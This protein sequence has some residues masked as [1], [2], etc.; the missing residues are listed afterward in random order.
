[1]PAAS[2]A[3]ATRTPR[4]RVVIA[5]IAGAWIVTVVAE[6]TGTGSLLHHHALIEDGP[7]L[8]AALTLFL[9]AWQVMV[10]AMMLPASLPA[11]GVF[12]AAARI[13]NRP[14]LALAVFVAAYAVVWTAFGQLAFMGDVVL[15]HVVD[16]TPWLGARPWLIE[17]GVLTFAGAYQFAPNKRHGLL[18]CRHPRVRAS[19]APRV[20]L[21]AFRLGLEHGF[22]C[23]GSSGALMLVMFA[24]GFA[25]LWWMIAL[26]G[27]MVYETTGR[28]AER[29]A[30]AAGLALIGLAL[31]V[32]LSGMQLVFVADLMWR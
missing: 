2:A 3:S 25:N 12:T 19:I 30:S 14:G 29:A 26:T 17:V 21:G 13:Q 32:A 20:E 6:A 22:A 4:P 31:L 1:M 5:A 16:A 10:A 9:V 18:A 15:H 24:A 11:I 27:V 23:L 28:H 7:P 8:W